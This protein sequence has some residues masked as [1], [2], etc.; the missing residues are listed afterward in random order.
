ML[1]FLCSHAIALSRGGV[2]FCMVLNLAGLTAS[3]NKIHGSNF[4]SY[5]RLL[6]DW[7][8][9][10]PASWKPAAVEEEGLP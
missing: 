1:P 2:C 4:V 9:A 7:L 5:P 8:L 10:C 3:T 6:E